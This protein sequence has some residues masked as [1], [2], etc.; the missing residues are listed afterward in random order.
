MYSSANIQEKQGIYNYHKPLVKV[1]IPL[2]GRDF[3]GGINLTVV[4]SGKV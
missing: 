2:L 4:V 3:L 1:E